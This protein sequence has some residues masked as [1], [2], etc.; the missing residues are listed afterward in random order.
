MAAVADG[1]TDVA[2]AAVA[3]DGEGGVVEPGARVEVGA[4]DTEVIDHGPDA[5]LTR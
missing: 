1:A 4:G 5:T 2:E 3:E